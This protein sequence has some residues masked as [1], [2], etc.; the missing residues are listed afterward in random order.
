V[1]RKQINEH[2]GNARRQQH[3][4]IT[5]WPGLHCLRTHTTRSAYNIHTYVL[6]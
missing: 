1:T 4:T 6:I 2:I 5:S 3:R